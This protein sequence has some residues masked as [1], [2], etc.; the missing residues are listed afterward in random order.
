MKGIPHDEIRGFPFGQAGVD[1]PVGTLRAI[2]RVI[3]LG[4][5]QLESTIDQCRRTFESDGFPNTIIRCEISV[6]VEPLV[7]RID[8]RLSQPSF[9]LEAPAGLSGVDKSSDFTFT[10][11]KFN[12]TCRV[13]I[14]KF[15]SNK[16]ISFDQESPRLV[17]I[18]EELR[19]AISRLPQG[20]VTLR[21]VAA[22]R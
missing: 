18:R 4:G 8:P 20:K 10:D 9:V 12:G 5:D 14:R 11:A 22:Q 16:G 2:D 3:E 6:P 1:V 13:V 21:V 7:G 15:D 17:T 19:R